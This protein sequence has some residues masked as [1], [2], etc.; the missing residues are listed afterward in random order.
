MIDE[1]DEY[2][3]LYIKLLMRVKQKLWT[4]LYAANALS[5]QRHNVD[6]FCNAIIAAST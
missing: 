6:M 4:H 1:H 2:W 5:R 3:M